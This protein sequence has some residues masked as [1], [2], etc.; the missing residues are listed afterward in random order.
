MRTPGADTGDQSS[1]G[2]PGI[3]HA[4]AAVGLWQGWGSWPSCVDTEGAGEVG[5]PP[6]LVRSWPAAA[7]PAR[8]R[9][10]WT[11]YVTV[12]DALS[13]PGSWGLSLR[14]QHQDM[15]FN[16]G[17]RPLGLSRPMTGLIYLSVYK[18]LSKWGNSRTK[19][20]TQPGPHTLMIHHG[21]GHL[22]RRAG[23]SLVN[24]ELRSRGAARAPV[25]AL[26]LPQGP[27][28][29]R[30]QHRG[31]ALRPRVKSRPLTRCM[32]FSKLLDFA[33]PLFHHLIWG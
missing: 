26:L 30:G 10:H 13:F 17:H 3:A 27:A 31:P 24:H 16:L 12:C 14:H 7:S 28:G 33:R 11:C 23:S 6:H 4:L 21:R 1:Q 32:T 22:M 18:G 20:P 9:E 25:P 15:L 8:L 5:L 29:E 2:V 19:A